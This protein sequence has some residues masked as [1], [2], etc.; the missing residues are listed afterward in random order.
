MIRPRKACFFTRLDS[1]HGAGL[2]MSER[3]DLPRMPSSSSPDV[4]VTAVTLGGAPTL[5]GATETLAT[6]LSTL[7]AASSPEREARERIA[8]L[9][10][11]ARALGNE[12]QA[13]LL[14]HEM[15]RLY[16]DPL[17]NPRNAAMA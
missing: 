11:E 4:P 7:P 10:R 16:E 5:P 15:G 8:T 9:E 6:T 2:P 13:A 1:S 17:K 14:L 3:N 12:P